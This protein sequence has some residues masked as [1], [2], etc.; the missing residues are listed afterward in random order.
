MEPRW[1][2]MQALILAGGL[3]TRLKPLV[4]DRPKPM[5]RIGNKPFLEYQI[6]FL[7]NYQITSLILCVG[8]LYEHI[9]GYFG[10]GSHWGVRIDYSIENQLLGTAG[11][12][13][14]AEKLVKGTV[15]ALN[16]DSY[17]DIDLDRLIRLHESKRARTRRYLGTIALAEAPDAR[18]Y[19][20]VRTNQENRILSFEEKP[21]ESDASTRI[22]A[23]IY[24]LEPGILNFVQPLQKMSLEREVF[25]SVLERGYHL[26]GYPADGFFVDIGT[27]R[28][29][30]R[31]QNYIQ[32]R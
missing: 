4:N 11:A 18:G 5:V 14:N 30:R 8:Y 13:K 15:L 17:F 29:L 1:N 19:G 23:G 22:N 7:K 6:E 20:S 9:Q 26:F 27:P 10:D 2:R 24:V 21:E 28:G 12:L 3:G 32:E 25:P 31:F 16:G